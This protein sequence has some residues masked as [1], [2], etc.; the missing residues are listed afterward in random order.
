MGNRLLLP[1]GDGTL[2]R[3]ELPGEARALVPTL[4]HTRPG[5]IVLLENGAVLQWLGHDHLIALDNDARWSSGAW[6]PSGKLV[7]ASEKE[8]CLLDVDARGIH[9]IKRVPWRGHPPL[10][11][12]SAGEPGRFAVFTA[13]GDVAVFA[14]PG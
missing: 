4:A 10:A 11:V 2:V 1:Q 8:I 6:T 12:T 14:L 3:V 5:I 13:K 9:G 7:L